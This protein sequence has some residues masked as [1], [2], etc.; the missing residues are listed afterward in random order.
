VDKIEKILAV[1]WLELNNDIHIKHNRD[2]TPII[3][4]NL[5]QIYLR[6]TLASTLLRSLFIEGAIIND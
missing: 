3:I 5:G 4:K 2:R 6:Y 1:F